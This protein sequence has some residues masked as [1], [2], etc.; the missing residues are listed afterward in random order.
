MAEAGGR[1][2]RA[3]VREWM[4]D[5]PRWITGWAEMDAPALGR[6]PPT[7][8]LFSFRQDSLTVANT[9]SSQK[10]PTLNKKKEASDA[11]LCCQKVFKNRYAPSQPVDTLHHWPLL[12]RV[13]HIFF[14]FP[15]NLLGSCL[16]S[17]SHLTYKSGDLNLVTYKSSLFGYRNL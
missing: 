5:W 1:R 10:R 7:A 11:V 2:Q 17:I 15:V 16:V 8:I 6:G 9:Y 14:H 4:A 12:L 3:G 13:T